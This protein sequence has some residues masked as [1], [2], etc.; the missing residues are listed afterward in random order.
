MK[1]PKTRSKPIL[2]NVVV[3]SWYGE[4][5]LVILKEIKSI[6]I[7]SHLDIITIMHPLGTKVLTNEKIIT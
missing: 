1:L 4:F 3:I 5:I 2:K 7:K 6:R